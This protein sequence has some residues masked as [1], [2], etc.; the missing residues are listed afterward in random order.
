MWK[1]APFLAIVAVDTAENELKV[2]MAILGWYRRRVRA[3]PGRMVKKKE[4][5]RASAGRLVRGRVDLVSPRRGD[6]RRTALQWGPN[7][8]FND[9]KIEYSIKINSFTVKVFENFVDYF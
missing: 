4:D 3:G 5:K 7:K 9:R 6:R 1:N 2:Q 8:E